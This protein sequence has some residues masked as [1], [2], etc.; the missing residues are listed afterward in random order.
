MLTNNIIYLSVVIS[1]LVIISR[2]VLFPFCRALWIAIQ[3]APVLADDIHTLKEIIA[4]D[5]V[6]QL[7]D[8]NSK[9][10]IINARLDVIEGKIL[11]EHN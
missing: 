5:V 1:A 3:I 6:N 2:Y 9:I 10:T 11:N 8:L 7:V 4:S